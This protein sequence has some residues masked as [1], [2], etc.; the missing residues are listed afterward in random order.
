MTQRLLRGLP[1]DI[2]PGA[3]FD[4]LPHTACVVATDLLRQLELDQA[5]K[6]VTGRLARE[7][8]RVDNQPAWDTSKTCRS[9]SRISPAEAPRSTVANRIS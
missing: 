1:G 6:G 5:T 7:A 9:C 4:Q 3:A 8:G 2:V